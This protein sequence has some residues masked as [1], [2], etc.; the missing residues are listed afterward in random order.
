V[1][2]GTDGEWEIRVTHRCKRMDE[3]MRPDPSCACHPHLPKP[4]D[5]CYAIED[6]SRRVPY[7]ALA[8]A[9]TA[10]RQSMETRA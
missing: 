3:H 6:R 2:I 9:E 1:I 8:D 7:A 5:E 10:H 4:C